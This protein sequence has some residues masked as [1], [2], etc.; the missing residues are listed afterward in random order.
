[1]EFHSSKENWENTDFEN[2][3]TEKKLT[4]RMHLWRSRYLCST[5]VYVKADTAIG[6]GVI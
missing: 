5:E 3:E 2:T 4:E 6:I 1:M